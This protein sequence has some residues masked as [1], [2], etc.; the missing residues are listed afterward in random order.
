[1]TSKERIL[2][3]M[4]N[5]MIVASIVVV[6]MSC[7]ALLTGMM[8]RYALRSK[9]LDIPNERSSHQV[10]VPRGGGIAMVAVFCLGLLA[11]WWADLLDGRS[12]LAMLPAAA[13]VALVGLIDDK[14]GVTPLLR[15]AAHVVAVG[16]FL[17]AADRPPY[18]GIGWV[19]TFPAI[20]LFLTLI[21]MVWLLNLFNFM[22]GID[23]IAA[24]EALLVST[25]IGLA[26]WVSGHGE[27]TIF[28]AAL[29]ASAC[30]GFLCWNWPPARIFMGDA[31]S[32]FL[33]IATG[34]LALL[35]ISEATVPVWIPVILV[36]AF[37]TDS[38]VTLMRRVL[39][40]ERWHEAHRTHAYQWLSR[41]WKGHLP[42]IL[43]LV[44]IQVLWLLPLA[45]LAQQIPTK[46]WLLALAAYLP[47]IALAVL[48]G[49]GR[50]ESK[51]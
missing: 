50:A 37:V 22:D 46:A 34:M 27:S 12:T 30:A 13:A 23:G 18:L 7:S 19:D 48:A 33:G 45:M 29:L 4:N 47:L 10:P 2:R 40:G 39:R 28:C 49:A 14:R 17:V 43:L 24:T 36:A 9:L 20:A 35:L 25:G 32:G 11:M 21:S 16:Y 42:V 51:P 41:L 15:L 3:N 6:S 38:T 44:A 8:R 31:G 5:G 1:L 26:A